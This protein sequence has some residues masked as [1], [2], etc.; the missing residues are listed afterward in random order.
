MNSGMQNHI[1]IQRREVQVR[2]TFVPLDEVLCTGA[3]FI[4]VCVKPSFHCSAHGADI[5]GRFCS[6]FLLRL[7]PFSEGDTQVALNFCS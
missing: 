6:D 4:F 7:V 3:Y 5:F 2:D 1:V